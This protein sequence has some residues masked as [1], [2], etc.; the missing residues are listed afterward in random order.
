MTWVIKYREMYYTFYV[1]K[2]KVQNFI[3]LIY[4]IE[5]L[6]NQIRDLKKINNNNLAQK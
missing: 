5:L 3:L 4:G 2:F 6:C 1:V